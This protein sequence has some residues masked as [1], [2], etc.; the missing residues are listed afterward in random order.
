M[1]FQQRADQRGLLGVRQRRRVVQHR[2]LRLGHAAVRH[3]VQG[4]ALD[5]LLHRVARHLVQRVPARSDR[6]VER[7]SVQHVVRV[8]PSQR[9]AQLHGGPRA[10]RLVAGRVGAVA[11]HP[12]LHI[13]QPGE[14]QLGQHTPAIPPVLHQAQEIPI[15]LQHLAALHQRQPLA[16]PL[17]QRPVG[18]PWLLV[19]PIHHRRR[20]AL[21]RAG[22]AA[23]VVARRAVEL[24]VPDVEPGR[25]IPDG[26]GHRQHRQF[27]RQQTGQVQRGARRQQ[28]VVV[29]D[30]VRVAVVQPLVVRH[31]RVGCMDAHA[32]GDDLVERPTGAKQAVEHLA[33]PCLVARQDALLKAG[34]EARRVTLRDGARVHV[35]AGVPIRCRTAGV[36]GFPREGR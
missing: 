31:V 19:R 1:V 7:A 28:A 29:V 10:I 18:V 36:N 30:E 25:E 34:I 3:R 35:H 22:K 8:L 4:D 20:R 23:R 16:Q 27:R 33:R 11:V 9:A 2:Q 15:G 14:H 5:L 17:R 12:V 32:L 26:L 21:D 13:D 6:D 24:L